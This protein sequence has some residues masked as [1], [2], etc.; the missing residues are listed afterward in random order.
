MA[1]FSEADVLMLMRIQNP[2]WETGKPEKQREG[3]FHRGEYYL[4]TRTL[5]HSL[6]RFPVMTGMRRVGKST[7]VY[8]IIGDLL[9]AGVSP[10][11][12]LYISLDTA[13]LEEMGILRL[14]MLY[15]EQISGERDFYLFLDEV[16]K[17]PDWTS[18]MKF[19][20]DSFPEVHAAA[21][22]SS[23]GL[24]EG[25][26]R[27]TGEGRLRL[28][29]VPTLSFFEYCRMKETEERIPQVEDVF[30]LHRL[31]LGEQSE[32]MS[33]LAAL[34]PHMRRYLHLGGFPEYVRVRP[35]EESYALSLMEEN[36]INKGIY[37]DLITTEKANPTQLKRLFAYLC[38]MTSNIIN[39]EEVCREMNG[40]ANATVVR[41]LDILE[42][43]GL[44]YRAQQVDTS[45]KKILKARD[46]I[47]IADSG[48]REA[49]VSGLHAQDDPVQQGYLIE[50]AAYRHTADYCRC[51][52]P[53]WQV[54]YMIQSGTDKEVDIVICDG[55]RILQ[56]VE[57]KIRKHSAIRDTDL[58]LTRSLGDRPGYIVTKSSADYG[59]TRRDK[60]DLYRIPAVAYLYLLGRMKYRVNSGNQQTNG[61]S[62]D[63]VGQSGN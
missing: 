11:K 47:H 32:I 15:R 59:L 34:E 62:E 13:A 25:K 6:R 60:G 33:G 56:L 36:I 42:R 30:Q 51:V 49:I 61:T 63:T 54:G 24:I 38:N 17:D 52:D 55:S 20:Y 8:Q 1:V 41:Y 50:S 46:K 18:A 57:S 19:V 10:R 37:N 23:S 22:G 3:T 27:E 29:R 26:T 35:E 39:V 40:I 28:I 14:L 9:R 12:I 21:T 58:I 5:F 48:I 31:S 44:I 43:A 53:R 16:Q 4:C 7:I 45:G 2:W